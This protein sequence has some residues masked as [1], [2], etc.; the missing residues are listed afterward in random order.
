MNDNKITITTT[1]MI[2]I[3]IIIIEVTPVQSEMP[4]K[5]LLVNFK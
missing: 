5:L 4:K 2:I 1:T 3:I